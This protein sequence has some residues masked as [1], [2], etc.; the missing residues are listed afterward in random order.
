MSS[1]ACIRCGTQTTPLWR[2]EVLAGPKVLCN[3][4]GVRALYSSKQ[5]G[6]RDVTTANNNQTEQYRIA[7]DPSPEHTAQQHVWQSNKRQRTDSSTKLDVRVTTA[8]KPFFS[9]VYS[10]DSP[11]QN[12]ISW[13]VTDLSIDDAREFTDPMHAQEFI[14][15]C[16]LFIRAHVRWGHTARVLVKHSCMCV[17]LRKCV[18]AWGR[19]CGVILTICLLCFSQKH[20]SAAM[21]AKEHASLR[22]VTSGHVQFE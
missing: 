14:D 18:T 11:G 16:W 10:Y 3:A 15:E 7:A 17:H 22:P 9:L 6:S 19:V 5:R 8:Q 1:Q 2:P 21:Q 13:R 4:C 20:S 12:V